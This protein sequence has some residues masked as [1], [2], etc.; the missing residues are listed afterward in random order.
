LV[1][2]H[3]QVC[4]IMFEIAKLIVILDHKIK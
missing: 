4:D 1:F 3:I 2:I